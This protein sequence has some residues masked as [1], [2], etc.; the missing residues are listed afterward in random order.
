MPPMVY[1]NLLFL[2]FKHVGVYREGSKDTHHQFLLRE[3]LSEL[4]LGCLEDVQVLVGLFQVLL[5]LLH[6]A[7]DICPSSV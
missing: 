5:P 1:L 7:A 3:P 4:Q 6:R 2:H